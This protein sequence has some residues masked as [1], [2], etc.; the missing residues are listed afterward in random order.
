MEGLWS[1]M[2]PVDGNLIPTPFTRCRRRIESEVGGS[3]SG[4][5]DMPVR[6]S[7]AKEHVGAK[8][9][10]CHSRAQESLCEMQIPIIPSANAGRL[11]S[12]L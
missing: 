9:S 2:S 8:T 1:S 4:I 7:S 5:V 3:S 12:L 6:G 11:R 10:S